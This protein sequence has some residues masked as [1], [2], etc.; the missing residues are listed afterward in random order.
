[1][2]NIL[3]LWSI[4]IEELSNAIFGNGSLRGMIFGYVAG[5]ETPKTT[6]WQSARH[7]PN[8]G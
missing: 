6:R 7:D 3:E 8:E 1:M 2:P 5:D 4:T